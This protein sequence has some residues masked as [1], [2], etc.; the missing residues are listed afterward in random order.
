MIGVL[1]AGGGL[2]GSAAAI[3]LTRLALSV[4]VLERGHFPREKPCGEGLMPAGVLA[5][6]RLGLNT[7]T[8]APF[9][10]GSMPDAER[11]GDDWL[12]QF[13]RERE[14]MLR[15]PRRL[16]VLLLWLAENPAFLAV[17]FEG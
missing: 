10:G 16:T 6:E 8:E 13:D 9:Q 11:G 5:L 4:E 3:H 7:S 12:V 2:A 14:T 15:D 1:I 17:T